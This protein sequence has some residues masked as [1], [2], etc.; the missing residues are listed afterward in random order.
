[1]CII[2]SVEIYS[3]TILCTQILTPKFRDITYDISKFQFYKKS[4]KIWIA[5]MYKLFFIESQ[6]KICLWKRLSYVFL[7]LGAKWCIT[8]G[9]LSG[10]NR[11]LDSS[12]CPGALRWKKSGGTGVSLYAHWYKIHQFQVFNFIRHSRH[13]PI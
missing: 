4:L 3:K 1:M 13:S 9:S 8:V 2:N 11:V 12:K 5:F 10:Q 6:I 7:S